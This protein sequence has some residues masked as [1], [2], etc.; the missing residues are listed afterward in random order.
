M[1]MPG[2][3][4]A[5][6]SAMKRV[7][8][9]SCSPYLAIWRPMSSRRCTKKTR[10][11]AR[12]RARNTGR[13]GTS[14]APQNASAPRLG[15]RRIVSLS[16]QLEMDC[17]GRESINRRGDGVH[18]TDAAAEKPPVQDEDADEIDQRIEHQPQA[19]GRAP[20]INALR[21]FEPR[22]DEFLAQLIFDAET[23]FV[24]DRAAPAIAKAAIDDEPF[25]HQRRQVV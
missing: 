17:L 21:R 7:R 19:T 6:R 20:L 13:H 18:E 1:K 15:G 10:P 3:P 16:P 24:L 22:K 23:A 2:A 4:A 12:A 8:T 5:S 11:E 25:M 9:G 14:Q